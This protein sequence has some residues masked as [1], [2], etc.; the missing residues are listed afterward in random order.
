MRD[1]DNVVRFISRALAGLWPYDPDQ[2]EYRRHPSLA[3][4]LVPMTRFFV[5]PSDNERD[6]QVAIEVVKRNAMLALKGKTVRHFE[7]IPMRLD[8]SI[9]INHQECQGE[10]CDG[11]NDLGVLFYESEDYYVALMGWLAVVYVG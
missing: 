4:R 7:V 8:D 9:A 3:Q 6:V 11:C 2:I 10:G 5:M 1:S